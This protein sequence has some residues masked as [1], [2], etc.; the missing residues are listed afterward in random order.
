LT[1]VIFSVIIVNWNGKKLLE[2]CIVSVLSQSIPRSHYEVIVVDNASSDGSA[3]YVKENYPD[4]M[5]IENAT[6]RGFAAG[7]NDAFSVTRGRY[8]ALLNSD[9]VADYH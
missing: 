1:D 9:A 8:F 7:N 6:N 3:E 2:P 4:V 5:L